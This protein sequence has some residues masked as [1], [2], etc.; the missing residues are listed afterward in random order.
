MVVKRVLSI[1]LSSKYRAIV[2]S[3]ICNLAQFQNLLRMFILEWDK[4]TVDIFRLFNPSLLYS[5]IA[6]RMHLDKSEWQ[7]KELEGVRGVIESDEELKGWIEKLKEQKERLKNSW[8][9]QKVII[10]EVNNLKSW[11]KA[12]REYKANPEKFR[13][14]PGLPKP[15]KLRA[16][17]RF[18][19][20]VPCVRE[21]RKLWLK[22]RKGKKPLEVLLPEGFDCKVKEVRLV[23]DME[24]IEVQVVYEKEVDMDIVGM[25][26]A[27]IDLGLDNLVS[28]ASDNPKLKS[29]IISGKELKSY[30]R[31]FNK[32]VAEIRSHMDRILNMINEKKDEGKRKI[33][34]RHYLWLKMYLWNLHKARK[35]KLETW[36][37]RV[38]R[39]LAD[40][41]Y[42]TGHRIVYIGKD[43]VDKNKIPFSRIVNQ[44]YV[45]IPHRKFV[46]MLKYKCEELGI[47][48]V[49]VDERYTS[50]ASPISDDVVHI[51]S[52]KVNGEDIVFSGKRVKRGLYK[53]LKLN[54]VF[55]A[56][57]VGAMNILKV[58]AKL[59]RLLLNMK[60]LFT[61]LCNPVKFRLWNFIFNLKS[62]P[63]SLLIDIGIGASKPVVRQEA[64]A[65]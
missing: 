47:Q 37:H 11:A 26:Q 10:Q 48:V 17:T 38:T 59:R 12:L 33:L 65:L 20:V 24:W 1:R 64:L 43:A 41:L 21:G 9:C 22:L 51:Q 50:K 55:N 45:Y 6:D 57:L 8:V 58:G 60:I 27:G 5:L 34:E 4:R 32:K 39:R 23:Y 18:T 30:N 63:K 52:K 2:R 62:N 56:D 15:R 28:V 54:K 19:V 16:L 49:E 3:F 44:N 46:E 40:I 31:W 7:R 36:M 29:F 35:R 25:Y 42:E 61:K 14:R 53:D 13:G